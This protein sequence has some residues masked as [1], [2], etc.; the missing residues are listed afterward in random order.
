MAGPVGG[1]VR[2]AAPAGLQRRDADRAGSCAGER[3]DMNVEPPS[4]P[5]PVVDTLQADHRTYRQGG[6]PGTASGAGW[7]RWARPYVSPAARAVLLLVSLTAVIVG[8]ALS[9]LGIL[10]G[11]FRLAPADLVELVLDL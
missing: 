5:P 8:C 11:R 9:T 4:G 1:V 10:L 7:P 2:W 3:G 6:R